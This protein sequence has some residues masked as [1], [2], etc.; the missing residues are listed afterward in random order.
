M[1]RRGYHAVR[2]PRTCVSDLLKVAGERGSRLSA[3][4]KSAIP[5]CLAGRLRASGGTI[6][7]SSR[8]LTKPQSPP[9]SSSPRPAPFAQPGSEMGLPWQPVPGGD[10]LSI[11]VAMTT[12][13]QKDVKAD[14]ALS[15]LPPP[16]LLSFLPL[17]SPSS[18]LL[19]SSPL[20]GPLNFLASSSFFSSLVSG[21]FFFFFFTFYNMF[22][23]FPL[24][25]TLPLHHPPSS[26]ILLPT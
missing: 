10:V 17:P 12:T 19:I 20:A 13:S 6:P 1:W 11:S 23:T 9:S 26:I 14:R 7:D 4:R 3:Y 18:Y 21:F 24:T 16:H 8:R 25:V 5:L 2:A 15:H 22:F